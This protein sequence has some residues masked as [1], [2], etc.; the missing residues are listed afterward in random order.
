[1]SKHARLAASSAHRWLVCAGSVGEGG[2]PSI[3]AATGTFAHDIAAKCLR[4][5]S[6]SPS[7]FLCKREKVDGFEV[8]CDLEMIEAVRFYCDTID[9]DMEKGDMHWIEM[10]LHKVAPKVDKDTGGTADCVRFRPSTKSLRVFDFKYGSGVYVEATDNKQ[11]KLYALLCLFE[12]LDLGYIAEE[13]EVTIVQPRFEGAAPVRSEKFRAIEL[14]EYLADIHEAAE[15]T[16]LPNPP[17]VAGDHCGFCPKARTCPEL[18]K[19]QH[20]LIA[21]DFGPIAKYD[22]AA[23]AI[24][25]GNVSLVKQR[26]KAIEEFAYT[27]AQR[28]IEIPGY[29]LVD[30]IAHRAWKSEGEMILWAESIALDPFKPREVISPAAM[31]AKLKETAPRGKKAGAAAL[32]EPFVERISSGTALVPVT[33]KRPPAKQIA[34]QDFPALEAK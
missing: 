8:E 30:K 26:I 24:A 2:D 23:L 22:V 15:R 1:V 27:E 25:L 14:L 21:T 13:V 28:G 10:S 33:D 3:Y 11:M 18:E 6:I 4:D 5:Q 31:E 32:L 7:D 20:A 17:L 16:R 12:L 9:E 29:K 19:R 34:A